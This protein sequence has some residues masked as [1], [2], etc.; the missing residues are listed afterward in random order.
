MAKAMA[1]AV[2]SGAIFSQRA[3][4]LGILCS[5]FSVFRGVALDK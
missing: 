1:A 5:W 2:S 3:V 4:A